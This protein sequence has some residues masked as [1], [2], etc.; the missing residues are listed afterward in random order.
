MNISELLM[1]IGVFFAGITTGVTLVQ[2]TS[3]LPKSDDK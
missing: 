1:L 2:L 3:Y